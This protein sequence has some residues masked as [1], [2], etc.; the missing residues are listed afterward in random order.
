[1]NSLPIAKTIYTN[2]ENFAAECP[3]CGKENIFN[4]ASDLD[5]FEPIAGRNVLCLAD[6]CGKEFRIIG[7]TLNNPH[8]MLVYDCY[9]LIEQKQYMN[10]ILTLTQAYEVFFNLFFR[11]EL[12]YKP[13]AVERDIAKFNRLSEMLYEKLKKHTFTKM[14]NHFLEYVLDNNPPRD[15]VEA[16]HKIVNLSDNPKEPKNTEIHNMN[17]STLKPLLKVVKNTEINTLRNKII[18]K[19]AYRPT[20]EEVEKAFEEAKT[21]LNELTYHLKLYDNIAFY[22]DNITFYDANI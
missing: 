11:I 4:R 15:F 7:D 6:A 5:T 9:K 16:E 10:T 22:S 20:R 12:L 19:Q 2:Y 1:M 8:E 13:F 14:R 18:H 21:T 3:W 17:N